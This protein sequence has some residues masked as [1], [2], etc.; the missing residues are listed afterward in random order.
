M[1]KM[2]LTFFWSLY[3]TFLWDDVLTLYFL[4]GL[5][6]TWLYRFSVVFV[7]FQCN[8]QVEYG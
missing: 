8:I 7:T 6:T 3:S 1:S 4:T 2:R 5:S